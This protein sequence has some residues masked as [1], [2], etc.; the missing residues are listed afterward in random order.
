MEAAGIE[1]LSPTPENLSAANQGG[2]ESGALGTN[3]TQLY[4]DLAA[5]IQAWPTLA[6]PIK[7][8]ILAMIR[9]AHEAA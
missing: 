1:P 6:E 7:A 3:H 8:A 9:V 4:P 5:V 2:A